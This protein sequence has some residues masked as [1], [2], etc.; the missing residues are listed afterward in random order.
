MK[1]FHPGLPSDFYQNKS[2]VAL[3]PFS[4]DDI[5][6]Y[7]R[8]EKLHTFI[9]STRI[10]ELFTTLDEDHLFHEYFEVLDSPPAPSFYSIMDSLADA[11]ATDEHGDV[12]LTKDSSNRKFVRRQ[13]KELDVRRIE[14]SIPHTTEFVFSVDDVQ[15]ISRVA[16]KFLHL[17]RLEFIY[18]TILRIECTLGA[19]GGSTIY[20]EYGRGY[21]NSLDRIL[22][23]VKALYGYTMLKESTVETTDGW[24]GDIALE[25][26]YEFKRRSAFKSDFVNDSIFGKGYRV[27]PNYMRIPSVQGVIGYSCLMPIVPVTAAETEFVFGTQGF[28]PSFRDIFYGYIKEFNDFTPLDK[29]IDDLLFYSTDRNG[30]L[31]LPTWQEF[32]HRYSEQFNGQLSRFRSSS[33]NFEVAIDLPASIMLDG[34]EYPLFH[35]NKSMVL[36]IPSWFIPKLI[37]PKKDEDGGMRYHTLTFDIINKYREA[38]R[39]EFIDMYESELDS[40]I[41]DYTSVVV[42]CMGNRFEDAERDVFF[43]LND[44]WNKSI[45]EDTVLDW[46]FDD[47][48]DGSC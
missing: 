9:S 30:H 40:L 19:I 8:R 41:A 27:L 6:R 33:E 46:L 25:I 35:E 12:L 18:T 16:S 17:S 21:Y 37:Y 13:I 15:Q 31:N 28:P 4:A 14:L 47:K 43:T 3:P 7:P 34:H 44:F 20:N 11:Y 42:G 39:K 2:T 36:G 1:R 38:V 29:Q 23:S 26:A 10:D 5:T 22:K 48:F 32:L 45:I 24:M